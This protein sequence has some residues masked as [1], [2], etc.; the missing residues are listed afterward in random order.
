MAELLTQKG[1]AN[2]Q[3]LVLWTGFSSKTVGEYISRMK[4]MGLLKEE[5]HQLS[6]VE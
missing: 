6:F 5:D 2:R 3:Q 1:K 4:R